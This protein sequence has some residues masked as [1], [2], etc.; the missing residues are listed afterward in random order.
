MNSAKK[1][2]LEKL[3]NAL[4]PISSKKVEVIY[5]AADNCLFYIT[6][7]E[8]SFDAANNQQFNGEE[9]LN[10]N[11]EYIIT[12]EEF[13]DIYL[14]SVSQDMNDLC[15]T[16]NS[17]VNHIQNHVD[18]QLLQLDADMNTIQSSLIETVKQICKRY[19]KAVTEKFNTNTDINLD[20][21]LELKGKVEDMQTTGL[22]TVK[23]LINL[24]RNNETYTEENKS[25]VYK[26][27]DKV[28]KYSESIDEIKRLSNNSF[29]ELVA[30]YSSDKGELTDKIDELNRELLREFEMRFNDEEY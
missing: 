10:I 26:N 11:K 19:K 27:L 1:N 7:S 4:H 3:K 15:N 12:A 9:E 6:P 25:E 2:K 18:N 24:I 28:Q 14:K 21:L 29:S 20:P 16:V 22:E 13:Q 30:N 8:I 23:T 17:Q 5:T